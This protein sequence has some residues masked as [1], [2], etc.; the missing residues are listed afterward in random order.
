[1]LMGMY[2]MAKTA[3]YLSSFAIGMV[4]GLVLPVVFGLGAMPSNSVPSR[5]LMPC[6]M[7]VPFAMA[8]GWSALAMYLVPKVPHG[9][10]PAGYALGL[11]LAALFG[12]DARFSEVLVPAM[13][14]I[15]A[16]Y[17][18]LGRLGSRFAI[19]LFPQ[20]CWS[21]LPASEPR[22]S[23]CGYVLYYAQDQLCPE[24]A[25]PIDAGTIDMRLARWEDGVLMPRECATDSGEAGA[26]ATVYRPLTP[27]PPRS[28]LYDTLR[29]WEV[30]GYYSMYCRQLNADSQA[31]F[32]QLGARPHFPAALWA[33]Q[34]VA[35]ALAKKILAS[36]AAGM[37]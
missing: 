37:Q 2:P 32:R 29:R 35:R 1:M 19:W 22:C 21:V 4:G 12:S 7:L 28:S 10:A 36:I 8:F 30:S 14:I 34:G 23:R 6:L 11:S 9:T 18:F 16:P 13:L 24:C 3:S 27:A 20:R 15:A 17:L 26:D 33:E 31:V 5:A 25:Q